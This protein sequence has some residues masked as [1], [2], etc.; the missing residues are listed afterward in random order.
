VMAIRDGSMRDSG[1]VLDPFY[2]IEDEEGNGG[3]THKGG[4]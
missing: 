3:W 2:I 1:M 4:D